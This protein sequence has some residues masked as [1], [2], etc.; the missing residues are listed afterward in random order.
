MNKQE[1]YEQ[2][3]T[4]Y[5]YKQAQK[6]LRTWKA[7]NKYSCKCVVH[8]RD[9]TEETRKYNEEHYE[10][11]GFNEDGTFEYGK[12][13]VFMTHAEHSS[14]HHK[15]H[16]C[17]VGVDNQ[18]YGKHHSQEQCDKW[19]KERKGRKLTDE[20]K[21]HISQNSA[22][23]AGFKGHKH[24]E[25]AKRQIA[26]NTSKALKGRAFSDEHRKA[27]SDARKGT[28]LSEQHKC[29]LKRIAE[30]KR[31]LYNVY[32]A[33]GGQLTWKAFLHAISIGDI[34]F[35]NLNTTIYTIGAVNNG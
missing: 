34:G 13:V 33:N 20:W 26:L 17:N 8:H 15:G 12:Y 24:T 1:Y 3:K 16:S 21:L 5:E 27:I 35:F 31:F 25:E 11:W 14:Y 30:G 23:V 28:T 19:S 9:D 7:E 6:L 18:F 4:P 2:H 22:H 10:R 29:K 32:K